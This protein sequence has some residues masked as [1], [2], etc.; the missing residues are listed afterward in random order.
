MMSDSLN[1][2]KAINALLVANSD[3]VKKVGKKIYPLIADSTTT[4]PFIVYGR[5]QM[6]PEST[7]DNTGEQ[8]YVNVQIATE[9]YPEGIEIANYVRASIEGKNGKFGT[10]DI[11]DIQLVDGDEKVMDDTFIQQLYFKIQLN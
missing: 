7:K 10:I 1:I 8:I 2:G 6:V 9:R 4:F 5:Y 11:D 3:I